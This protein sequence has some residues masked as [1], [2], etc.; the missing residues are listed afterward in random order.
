MKNVFKIATLLAFGAMMSACTT[1]TISRATPM[2]APFGAATETGDAVMVA[3]SFRVSKMTVV[4]PGSLSVSEENGIKP[5]AD[6]VWREDPYGNR[7]EQVK[8]VMEAGLRRGTVGLKGKQ[9]VTL[10]VQL[11]KFHAQTERVRYSNLPSKHEIEFLLTVRDANTGAVIV[12]THLVDATFD[13]LG[14][15][16]AIAA[17]R[18]G[19]TQRSRINDHLSAVI[20]AELNKPITL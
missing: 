6:I 20:F 10:D 17:D 15:K 4:V 11:V 2:D 16:A 9:S 8:A 14:G 18:A 3:P 12:P 19:I 5:R 7:L 13:A 1:D